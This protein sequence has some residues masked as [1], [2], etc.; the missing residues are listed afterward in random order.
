MPQVLEMYLTRILLEKALTLS[1]ETGRL[2][3]RPHMAKSALARCP[4]RR[5]EERAILSTRGRPAKTL[6][7]RPYIDICRETLQWSDF[8]TDSEFC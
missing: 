4:R 7:S 3:K 2:L 5:A 1:S 6:G 8:Y